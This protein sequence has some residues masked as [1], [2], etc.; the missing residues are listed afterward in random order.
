MP[1]ITQEQLNRLEKIARIVDGGNIAIAKYILDMEDEYK[2]QLDDIKKTIPDYKY[3]IENIKGKDGNNPI[4]G[5]DYYTEQEKQALV[6]E[7]YGKIVLPPPVNGITPIAGKDYPSREQITEYINKLVDN[8]PPPLD[9]YTPRKGIDYFTSED[10]SNI[11]L[12]VMASLPEGKERTVEEIII[13]INN[14]PIKPEVQIDATH[15]KNLPKYFERVIERVQGGFTETPIKSGNGISITKDG[16]GSW[17][18]TSSGGNS[19][20]ETPTGTVNGVNRIFT[21]L[22]TPI[23]IVTDNLVRFLNIPAGNPDFTYSGGTIT[24]NASLAPTDFIKSFY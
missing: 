11:S 15:I 4:L 24:M 17:V 14:L 5:K 13:D 23:Y 21:V 1:N 19:N 10:I 8:M 7:V 18:I 22:N 6:D 3:L 9:G 2:K 16:S 12:D 20:N